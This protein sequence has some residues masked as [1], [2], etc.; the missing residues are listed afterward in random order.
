MS[1]AFRCDY[2]RIASSY[3]RY[4]DLSPSSLNLWLEKII[5]LGRI[6]SG[7]K[8]LDIGCGTGRLTIPLQQETQAEVYGLDLS[9]EM[10]E[11]AQGKKGAETVHWISGDAHALPFPDRSFDCT[12]MCLVLHHI[13]DKARAIE[14]MYRVLKPGEEALSGLPRI[15]RSRIFC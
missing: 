13:E 3:D 5:R 4:R 6:S 11:Q 9:A 2:G 10:L 12:F 15:S 7:A 1:K 14:E 8:V